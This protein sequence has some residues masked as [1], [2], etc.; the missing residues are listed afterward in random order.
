MELLWWILRTNGL[1]DTDIEN[2]LNKKHTNTVSLPLPVPIRLE[3][4]TAYWGLDQTIQF[5]TDIYQRDTKLYQALQQPATGILL[6]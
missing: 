5:R 6:R 4:R 1:S 2:Q 3:Y